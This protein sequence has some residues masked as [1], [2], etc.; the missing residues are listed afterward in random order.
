MEALGQ[1]TGGIA[2]D[3]NNLLTAILG[4]LES[5]R[6]RLGSERDE[7]K[8]RAALEAAER[9]ERA[10]QSLLAFARREPLRIEVI[11]LDDVLQRA[12]SLLRHAIGSKIRLVL[13][14]AVDTWCVEAD[15]NELELALL[16]LAVNARAAMPAGGCLRIA[17]ANR[18]LEGQPNGLAGEFVELSVADTGTG[19]PPDVLARVFEPFFTTKEQGRG[20]GLGLSQVYRFA[21]QRG[22]TV[23]AS[24][25]V[26]HGTTI[27]L[28]L[29]RVS[30]EC[31]RA[32]VELRG[33]RL[34][35]APLAPTSRRGTRPRPGS[36]LRSGSSS[37]RA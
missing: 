5:L 30:Q 14:L 7:R 36:A 20:T 12:E 4:N 2:H 6:G 26:G 3:F 16:N 18:R 25:T 37:S 11:D 19:M 31:D 22:G 23:T 33:S 13:A 35:L 8:L 28:F 1:V 15:A 32:R 34:E 21:A 10:I 9:G 29:P 24:S 17:T 27:T